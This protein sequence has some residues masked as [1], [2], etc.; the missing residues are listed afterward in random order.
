LKLASI[1]FYLL[2]RAQ[3]VSAQTSHPIYVMDIESI[4]STT[5]TYSDTTYNCK[6]YSL[7]VFYEINKAKHVRRRDKEFYVDSVLS[8]DSV[9]VSFKT[10]KQH[11]QTIVIPQDDF[12]YGFHMLPV[13]VE[14]LNFDGYEDLY[15]WDVIGGANSM[16]FYW[17]YNPKRGL[18]E[19]NHELERRLYRLK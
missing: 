12:N 1:L 7:K 4:V 6:S 8:A 13:F 2:L 5:T 9:V 16:S 18:F 15:I 10:G 19:R 3:D 14:D 17:L 11:T